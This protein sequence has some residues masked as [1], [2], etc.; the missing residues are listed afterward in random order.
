MERAHPFVSVD[1]LDVR[2]RRAEHSITRHDGQLRG[3]ETTQVNL[4]NSAA[5]AT[6]LNNVGARV[7]SLTGRVRDL[8]AAFEII[9]PFG[10]DL[11][12]TRASPTYVLA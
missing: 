9:A 5:S 6:H 8:E 10:P 3:V 12:V 4:Q 7:H 11:T 2:L 1:A